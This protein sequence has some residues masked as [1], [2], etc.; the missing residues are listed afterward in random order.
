LCT[1]QVVKL[2]M[3]Y[4]NRLGLKDRRLG[5]KVISWT[6]GDSIG[7]FWDATGQSPF[8]RLDYSL[9]RYDGERKECDYR[10]DLLRQPSNLGKGNRMYFICPVSGKRATILYRC[11]GSEYFKHRE[12]FQN[13][14]YYEQQ[15]IGK[16]YRHLETGP[17]YREIEK[18]KRD[19]RQEFY[20]G[21]RTKRAQRLEA[22]ENRLWDKQ[23]AIDTLVY[24]MYGR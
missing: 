19:R 23:M 20:K 12:A 11:Y 2:K 18:L 13:R 22:L 3:S 9:T 7:L 21:Q 16:L 15:T 24:N 6:S 17:L 1:H 10:I 4:L 8:I 14:I 5:N